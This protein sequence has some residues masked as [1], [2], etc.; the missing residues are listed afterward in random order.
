MKASSISI[1]KSRH[2][3]DPKK[4]KLIRTIFEIEDVKSLDPPK[5][6]N[7]IKINYDKNIYFQKPN[8]EKEIANIISNVINPNSTKTINSNNIQLNVNINNNYYGP[9]NNNYSKTIDTE[10][11]NYINKK[12]YSSINSKNTFSKTMDST[13]SINNSINTNDNLNNENNKNRNIYKE[14]A[15]YALL[16]FKS[17]QSNKM[18]HFRTATK[19]NLINSLKSNDNF[20]KTMK[21]I[22]K[23]EKLSTEPSNSSIEKV[24]II[25][26]VEKKESDDLIK[27]IPCM[28]CGNLISFDD[29]EKHSYTCTKVSDE[30]IKN[31][32]SK[33]ELN[34][35]D[36]KLKK[37]QEHLLSLLNMNNKKNN[38][39]N[40]KNDIEIMFLST[41][42]SEYI[43]EVLE[44]Q[45][46][47]IPSIKQFK[48]VLKN[49][50][51]ISIKYKD[52]ISDLILIDRTKT[53]VNE[54]LK[55]FKSSYKKDFDNK[56]R[57][58]SKNGT[59]KYEED[60]KIKLKQLEKLNAETELEKTKVKNLR[61]SAG[62]ANRPKYIRNLSN[63]I[64]S[65]KKEESMI[66]DYK[67]NNNNNNNNINTVKVDEIIS[68][69]ENNTSN[70]FSVNTS[71]SNISSYNN[72]DGSFL[73]NKF[74]K[75]NDNSLR[76]SLENLNNI[77]NN[78]NEINDNR[79]DYNNNN[80]N[81]LNNSNNSNDEYEKREKKKFFNE[82][83]KIKFEKL[84]STHKGQLINQKYIWDE[85][86]RQNIPKKNWSEFILG[87]LN[88]PYKYLEIQK[89]EK[90]NKSRKAPMAVITEE[91]N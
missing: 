51:N 59:L 15:S 40:K 68:D 2:K 42:L 5:N 77:Y 19:N 32:I 25:H 89:K 26:K 24:M 80:N 49:L 69:I 86:K 37:L 41:V 54:K 33:V 21:N 6:K 3:R 73:N 35:I 56:K 39:E 48:K 12:S 10:N 88:N 61:K 47:D 82:V 38:Y 83:L 7:I 44:L 84:H 90:R 70:I 53:L 27:F 36:Y 28:N 52:N 34:P 55:I 57:N 18:N 50:E 78:E 91:N 87:E 67:E 65:E 16:E 76:F 62:P 30:I 31:D 79:N 8:Q 63:S 17:R 9:Y 75:G 1:N 4:S 66:S 45:N 46:I 29:I 23:P 43:K 71:M 64:I 13:N 74:L 81:I 85:C 20:S 14:K 58:L 11:H 22:R 60:L 72:N